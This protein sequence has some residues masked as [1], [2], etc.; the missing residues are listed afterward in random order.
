VVATQGKS[1]ETK[2]LF[3]QIGFPHFNTGR[4]ILPVKSGAG[5]LRLFK[6]ERC[7][8][9]VRAQNLNLGQSESVFRLSIL[10]EKLFQ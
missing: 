10:E 1:P 4:K 6:F 3:K 7:L 9:R 8:D 2:S 5:K